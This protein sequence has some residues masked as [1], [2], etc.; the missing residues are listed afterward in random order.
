MLF[1]SHSTFMFHGVGFSIT[2]QLRFEE[3]NL[4]EMMGTILSDQNRIGSI[5]QERTKIDASTIESLFRDAQTKDAAYA[6]STG[7][8]HEVCDFTVPPGGP[9]VSLVFQR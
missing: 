8:V 3:K 7:I 4:R 5:I 6:V 9:I 1:R 2:Q